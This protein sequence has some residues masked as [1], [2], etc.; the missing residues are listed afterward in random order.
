M[1]GRQKERESGSK[2][3]S[4]SVKKKTRKIKKLVLRKERSASATDLIYR[5]RGRREGRR[6]SSDPKEE[7][8][9]MCVFALA[10]FL[11][12]MTVKHIRTELI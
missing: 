11:S 6:D 2:E 7:D 8:I 3:D 1:K 9:L 5:I 10:L 12:D 4:E